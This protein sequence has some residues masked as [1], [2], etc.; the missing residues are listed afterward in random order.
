MNKIKQFFVN[1]KAEMI[2]VS[3]PSRDELLNST[4]VVI[5]SVALLGLYVGLVDLLFT[6]IIGN[7]IK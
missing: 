4:T 6:F 3:W 1:V 7:I 2:K 5:I